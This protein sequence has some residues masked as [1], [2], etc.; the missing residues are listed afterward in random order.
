ML[1]VFRFW[2]TG[3]PPFH[4][5]EFF[6]CLLPMLLWFSSLLRRSVACVW[7]I[8]DLFL[9]VRYP[10]NALT[11]LHYVFTPATILECVRVIIYY[12]CDEYRSH[13]CM[14]IC[15]SEAMNTFYRLFRRAVI[16]VLLKRRLQFFAF[17][18]W[19]DLTSTFYF[20]SF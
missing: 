19:P 14:Q 2:R 1:N 4:F 17:F 16:Y 5:N 13:F 20:L 8:S 3:S 11:V 10:R 6:Y 15:T 18:C 12:I 9:T 7:I